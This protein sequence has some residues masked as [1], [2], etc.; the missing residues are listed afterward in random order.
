VQVDTAGNLDYTFMG[1]ESDK[2][3]LEALAVPDETVDSYPALRI[4][5]AAMAISPKNGEPVEIPI[6]ADK[7]YTMDEQQL[8]EN[9][10]PPA[11]TI[12]KVELMYF[13][14][15][16]HWPVN[17][18]DGSTPY[19]QP[20]WRFYGHYANGGEFEV[21]VQALKEESLFPELDPYIQGG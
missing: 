10:A 14:S 20:V 4:Y 8:P 7:P 2:V 21:L 16:P 6:T 17:N 18:L 1:T 9:Y 12:E 11:L 19:I 3:L 15:N 13:V 5:S